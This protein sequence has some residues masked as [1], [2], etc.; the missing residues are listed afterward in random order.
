MISI[1]SIY[2]AKYAK[3]AYDSFSV[4]ASLGERFSEKTILAKKK[5]SIDMFCKLISYIAYVAPWKTYFCVN[6]IINMG[7]LIKRLK[8]IDF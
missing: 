6:L 7:N 4:L 8:E 5:L 2:K 3:H 1:Y